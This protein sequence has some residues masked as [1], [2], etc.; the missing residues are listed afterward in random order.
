[1]LSI[2]DAIVHT[3]L[4][5]ISWGCR[6]IKDLWLKLHMCVLIGC[7]RGDLLG[8]QEREGKMRIG[9]RKGKKGISE[10]ER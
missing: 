5:C 6:D 2:M 1:M 10:R 8:G 9:E 4:L 3:D 7:R